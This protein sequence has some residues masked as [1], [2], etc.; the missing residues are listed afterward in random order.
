MSA[1]TI[2]Q[3]VEYGG[4]SADLPVWERLADAEREPLLELGCGVGR[5]A[6]H[7]ARRGHEVWAVDA[8]AELVD[9]LG[10]RAASE[11]LAVHPVRSEAGRLQLE[12]DFALVLAPM[13]LMQVLGSEARRGATLRRVASHLHARGRFAIAI[14]DADSLTASAPAP[15]P[16]VRELGGWVYSSLPVAVRIAERRIHV[17]RIRQSVAPDGSL[18]ED[19]H[20]ETLHLLDPAM[21]EAEAE[22]AGL[23][24]AERLPIPAQDG[25]LGATAVVVERP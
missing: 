3:E 15:V 19:H 2:W 25:Y 11:S 20:T 21:L 17:H 22:A 16:D 23:R 13:Q 10:E 4:Y 5:V 6:L 12:R 24:P 14:A 1:S 18:L 7:L 9:Q 8:D